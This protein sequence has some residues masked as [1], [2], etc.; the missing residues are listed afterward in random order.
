MATKFYHCNICGNI[1]AAVVSSGTNPF[2]CDCKMD[3]MTPKCIEEEKKY[4]VPV[5]TR[6]DEYTIK[7]RL[8]KEKH[9]M[10]KEH[11]ICFIVVETKCG[12][13]MRYLKPSDSDEICIL[14][15]EDPEAVYVYCNKHGLWRVNP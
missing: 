13:I 15:K 4:H 14:S 6:V 9:P 10:N 5:V 12:A 1:M 8:G 3:E 2:C 7:V 11:H